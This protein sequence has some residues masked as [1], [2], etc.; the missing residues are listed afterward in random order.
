MMTEEE[1]MLAR[2]KKF[3]E[4]YENLNLMFIQFSLAANDLIKSVR[5]LKENHPTLFD[6]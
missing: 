1:L 4:T 5:E 3:S 6:H 2:L